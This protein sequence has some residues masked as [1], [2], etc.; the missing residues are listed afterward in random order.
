[1]NDLFMTNNYLYKL[2]WGKY[3]YFSEEG[4]INQYNTIDEGN[5]KNII[6]T[7][8]CVRCNDRVKLGKL[9]LTNE[10]FKYCDNC[11]TKII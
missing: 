7:E 5:G 4:Y 11:E 10:F 6:N 2:I 3:Y 8:V 9:R 1:M